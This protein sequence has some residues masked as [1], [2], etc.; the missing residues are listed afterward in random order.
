MMIEMLFIECGKAIG[1]LFIN[2]LFYWIVL[3]A[4]GTGYQRVLQE[5][6]QF[7][8]KI[9]NVFSEL[10]NTWIISLVFGI[11][12]SCLT[13]G[14]GMVFTYE[15][16]LIL[17]VVVIIL[18]L[19]FNLTMLSASYTIG[20]TYL[21]I[22][23]SLLFFGRQTEVSIDLLSKVNFTSLVI[24][25]G[26]FL[27]IESLLV[28]KIKRNEMLPELARSERGGWIGQQHIK[29]LAIIPFFVLIPTGLIS[30]FASYWP[31]FP[32]GEESTF[33]LMLVPFV[34]GFDHVTRGRLAIHVASSLAKWISLLGIIVL[35]LGIASIYVAWLSFIAVILAILG[36]EYINYRHRVAD[37]EKSAYFNKMD[38]GLKVLAVI[39]GSPA[40]RLGILVGETIAKVN[41]KNV[42]NAQQFYE[43]LQNSGAYF[44]L[45]LIDDANELRFVQSAFYDD[46]HH[47]LGIV[48][49]DEPYRIY[50]K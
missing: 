43:A 7:G 15:T 30:P 11:L 35:L 38:D 47:E 23:I 6:M 27:I 49:T 13:L 40:D 42:M 28:G 14:A 18:S 9:F 24:L 5:R 19:T 41:D 36:R 39:P 22:L 31:F 32:L 37:K 17:S 3:L 2:P 33:S 34:I 10:K 21:F 44:K 50:S 16:I 4:I 46:D 1:R 26:I 20:I 25:L 12:I 29:K 8:F 45:N 48:F